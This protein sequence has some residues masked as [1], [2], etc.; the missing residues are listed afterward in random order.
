MT[1]KA[2]VDQILAVVNAQTEALSALAAAVAA[3]PSGT[4]PPELQASLDKLNLAVADIQAQIEDPTVP[5][6]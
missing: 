5:T 3:I 6:V 1:I 4:V 2:E